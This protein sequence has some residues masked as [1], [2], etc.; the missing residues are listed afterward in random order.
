MLVLFDIDGTILKSQHAGVQAMLDAFHQLHPDRRFSF[1]GIDIAGRL[2]TLIYGEM[3]DRHGVPADAESHEVFRHTY[4]GHLERRLAERNTVVCLD[5]VAEL[6]QRLAK[7]PGVELGLLTGNYPATGRL[8][9]KHAGLDPD[10]FKV[11]AFAMD[12]VTRRD[13][14]PVALQRYQQRHGSPLDPAHAIIIGD[15]PKDVDCA[16][17]NGCRVLGVATGEFT[18]EQLLACGAH[19]V[20]DK[21]SPVEPVLEWLLTHRESKR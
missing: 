21:L 16:L 20:V 1:D 19:H 15:T 8:K 12:G 2:D 17:H 3:A 7:E 9:V 4:S 18:A 5:G 14:P 11:N 6:V 13:L 10:L